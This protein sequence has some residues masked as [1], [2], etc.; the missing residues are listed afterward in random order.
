MD[1]LIFR[2]CDLCGRWRLKKDNFWYKA[3]KNKNEFRLP[4]KWGEGNAYICRICYIR[5][6][7]RMKR[8]WYADRASTI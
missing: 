3:V 7:N 8:G 1:F 5:I 6:R 4:K 2:K